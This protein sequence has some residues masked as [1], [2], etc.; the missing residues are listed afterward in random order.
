MSAKT[1]NLSLSAA[2]AA[3]LSERAF[4]S[5]NPLD[6]DN[7]CNVALAI[8]TAVGNIIDFPD[9]DPFNTAKTNLLINLVD[10]QFEGRSPSSTNA[11]DY[12]DEA[13]AVKAV[14]DQAVTKL[15]V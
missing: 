15:A 6:Y 14:F 7:V 13:L 2:L 1:Q 9:A 3:I 5:V 11:A 8:A 10:A 4:T 12:A